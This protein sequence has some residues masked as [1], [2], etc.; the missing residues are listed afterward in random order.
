VGEFGIADE[1]ITENAGRGI[2]E[3]AVSLLSNDSAAPTILIITGNHRTGARAIAAARHLRNRGHRVTMCL[4]GLEHEA[5]L[6]ENCRKQLD[7]FRKI[8][9]RVLKWEELSTR[10]A[11]ADLGPDLVVDALFGMHLS[12]DDL[13]TDDQGVAFEM[14]SWMNRSNVHVLSVDVPS[15]LNASTGKC[16]SKPIPRSK[17]THTTKPTGEMTLAEG[18]RLCVNATSVVCLGAPKTG[19]LNALLSGER[20][21]WNVSVADIGIPQIVWRKYGTRRRH[22]IDFGNKWVVPLKFQSPLP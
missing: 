10:L 21:S 1:I 15:G 12:F 4:L 13:R 8:G 17:T 6:L 5:E 9:G 2:A 19:V 3:A 18:G 16:A 7:I 14:I 11:T 22:G 20:L